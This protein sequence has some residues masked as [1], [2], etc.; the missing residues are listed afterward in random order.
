M[1]RISVSQGLVGLRRAVWTVLTYIPM[2][3][4]DDSIPCIWIGRRIIHC[5]IDH[6]SGCCHCMRH[7]LWSP[8]NNGGDLLKVVVR[9]SST[10]VTVIRYASKGFKETCIE[11]CPSNCV[12]S[13]VEA[14]MKGRWHGSISCL[15]SRD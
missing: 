15:G 13:R 8:K 1:P 2:L 5:D 3:S 11:W 12:V 10:K 7:R 14:C 6:G 9:Y 4:I